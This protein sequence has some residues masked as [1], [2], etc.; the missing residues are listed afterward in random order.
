MRKALT[1]PII[2]QIF[3]CDEKKVFG[4]CVLALDQ[5]NSENI[6]V[7]VFKWLSVEA[8]IS[9]AK[10]SS[11]QKPFI[12]FRLGPKVAEKSIKEN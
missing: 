5:I 10:Q 1:N 11:K 9:S 2:I 3:E 7:L 4:S 12:F 8:P 6:R